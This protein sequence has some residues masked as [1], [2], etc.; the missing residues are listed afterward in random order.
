[1]TTTVYLRLAPIVLLLAVVAAPTSLQSQS[2]QSSQTRSGATADAAIG[3]R[4]STLGLGLELGKQLADHVSARIGINVGS[5][6]QT[7]KN[8]SNL[9]YDV[10][11]K[12]QAAEA[13]IDYSPSKRGVFHFTA[14]LLTNPLTISGVGTPSGSGTFTLNGNTYTSA[15][16]GTLRTRSKFPGAM[17]YLGLGFGT[18]ANRGGRVK[19]LFDIGAAIGKPTVALTSTGAGSSATLQTDLNAQ[20]A[21]TQKD[22]NK[23]GAYPVIS[24]GLAIHL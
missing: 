4:L 16:V 24:L 1:M 9:T 2:S 8:Q 19:F 22:L 20:T 13:L 10:S 14:G 7:G 11:L 21:K 18:P 12:L 6:S 15:Q 23:L 5:F 17:P 3:I